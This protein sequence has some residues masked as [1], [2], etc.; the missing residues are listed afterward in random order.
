METIYVSQI[1]IAVKDQHKVLLRKLQ[2]WNQLEW[3]VP[4]LLSV[5]IYNSTWLILIQWI[6]VLWSG[7]NLT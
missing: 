3:S 5:I 7:D 1:G 6:T 2:N 4:Q